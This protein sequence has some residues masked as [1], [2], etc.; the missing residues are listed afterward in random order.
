MTPQAETWEAL[1]LL[2]CM[3]CRGL[4]FFVVNDCDHDD[5]EAHNVEI[6]CPDCIQDGQPT[7]LEFSGLTERCPRCNGKG[8]YFDPSDGTGKPEPCRMFRCVN[9][10]TLLTGTALLVA[11]IATLQKLGCEV[12]IGYGTRG[13]GWYVG[14]EWVDWPRLKV[15]RLLETEYRP[16]LAQ[17]LRL[18]LAAVASN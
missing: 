16:E 8:T 1:A 18:A 6:P 14:L 7:G 12:T 5:C 13:Q 9:G 4:K 3:G 2:P 11:A 17:A 10:R 15:R